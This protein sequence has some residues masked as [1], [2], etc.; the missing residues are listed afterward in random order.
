MRKSDIETRYEYGRRVPAVNVKVYNVPSTNVVIERFGCDEKTAEQAL[1]YS[2]DSQQQ[3]FWEDIHA[4]VL[5]IFGSHAK[6]Y[7][8]GRSGGWLVVNGLPDIESWDAIAVGRWAKLCKYCRDEIA[9]RTSAEAM[10]EDIEAN[11]WAK[12]FAEQYNFV[13]TATGP[14]CIADLKAEAISAGFG[15]V[16]RK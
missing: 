4:V 6:A 16:V 2:H 10:L 9:Y 5:D 1:S 12:P 11:Q 14:K 8:A 15:P 3:I 13:D 7:S